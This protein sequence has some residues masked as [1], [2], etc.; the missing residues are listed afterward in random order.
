MSAIV[1]GIA[2]FAEVT[3]PTVVTVVTVVNEPLTGCVPVTCIAGIGSVAYVPCF[4]IYAAVPE[5]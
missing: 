5:V 2:R 4:I 3:E 1:Q